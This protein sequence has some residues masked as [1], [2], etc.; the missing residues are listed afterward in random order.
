MSHGDYAG[1]ICPGTGTC[2][3]FRNYPSFLSP[4]PLGRE[5]RVSPMQTSHQHHTLVH[6]A[7]QRQTRPLPLWLAVGVIGSL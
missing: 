4:R 7:F 1:G 3:G 6:F 2:H 5:G